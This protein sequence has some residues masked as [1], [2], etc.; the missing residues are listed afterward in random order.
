MRERAQVERTDVSSDGARAGRARRAST[1]WAT[2]ARRPNAGASTSDGSSPL[3]RCG[4]RAHAARRGCA[5][6]GRGSRPDL[7]A[8]SHRDDTACAPCSTLHDLRHRIEGRR[9]GRD[10]RHRARRLR[11]ARAGTLGHGP[12]HPHACGVRPGPHSRRSAFGRASADRGRGRPARGRAWTA[13]G[14]GADRWSGV[15]SAFGG[16]GGSRSLACERER[17]D[18][19]RSAK[20]IGGALRSKRRPARDEGRRPWDARPARGEREV[21]AS[22]AE[23]ARARDHPIL[24]HS[25]RSALARSL[26]SRGAAD[27]DPASCSP[28]GGRWSSSPRGGRRSSSPR[29]A[30]HSP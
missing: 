7:A 16:V 22:R 19:R 26:L 14:R 21:G 30:R 4:P 5:P 8:S 27:G 3:R 9:G 17:T 18:G 25:S 1:S 2:G 10:R 29:G 6:V 23:P 15:E 24:G 11:R 28:R 12:G 20:G 13:V